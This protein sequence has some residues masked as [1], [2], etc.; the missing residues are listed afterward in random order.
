MLRSL[1]AL[2]ACVLLVSCT[3]TDKELPSVT[4][5]S[6][7]AAPGTQGD[8]EK[9]VANT[10]YF[11]FDRYNIDTRSEEVLSGVA[12]WL[13]TYSGYSVCVE[14]HTDRVGTAEYNLGLGSRRAESAKKFLVKS[15]VEASRVTTISYGK[16]A[17]ADLGTTKEA[18]AANRRARIV[19]V[20][21]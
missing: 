14:G 9:N 3:G 4:S 1:L 20:N 8:F 10:V 13:K 15:G 7:V 16:E 17:P 18:D 12:S 21:Q 6:E 5:S 11:G 19:L 2:T